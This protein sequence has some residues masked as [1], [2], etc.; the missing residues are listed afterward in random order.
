[1]ITFKE[2]ITEQIKPASEHLNKRQMTSLMKHPVY[3]SHIHTGMHGV[4]AKPDDND[5]GPGKTR[6]MI[7]ASDGSHR[8]HISMTDKGKVLSH[9]LYRRGEDG[10][11]T[12]WKYIKGED[13]K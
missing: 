10:K 6:N 1:M 12:V 2:F 13:G 8:L 11:T 3:K 4:F 9:S 5:N 7:V